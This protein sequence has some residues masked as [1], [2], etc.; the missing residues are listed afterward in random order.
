MANQRQVDIYSA[1]CAVCDDAVKLVQSLAC[2]SCNVMVRDMTDHIV[3]KEARGLGI[4]T[5]PAVVIDGKLADCCTSDGSNEK[6]LRA[7]GI[8]T[9]L[10]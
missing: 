2:S 9:P 4:T 8:G 7:A 10:A 3:V 1:G 6:I 5:V